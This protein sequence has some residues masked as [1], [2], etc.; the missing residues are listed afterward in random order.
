MDELGKSCRGPMHCLFA[1]YYCCCCTSHLMCPSLSVALVGIE[2]V[3]GA[4]P[5][6]AS[7]VFKSEAEYLAVNP[8]PEIGA[9]VCGW[10]L[11]FN[12]VKLSIA[13][14]HLQ[15]NEN[16]VFV[17]TNK[18]SFDRLQDRTVPG[19]RREGVTGGKEEA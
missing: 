16:I 4:D 2:C 17:A 5:E 14:L 6:Y 11:S 7:R 3:G 18:D 15:K 9:V 19:K 10:D 12:F 8:D 13:S 1:G